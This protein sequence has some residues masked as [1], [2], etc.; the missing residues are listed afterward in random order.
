[1]MYRAAVDDPKHEERLEASQKRAAETLAEMRRNGM[2]VAQLVVQLQQLIAS[3]PEISDR[4]VEIDDCGSCGC[5]W[6]RYLDAAC[7]AEMCGIA[8]PEISPPCP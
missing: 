8:S 4:P 2:T 1:M 3:H 5:G 7:V 6:P